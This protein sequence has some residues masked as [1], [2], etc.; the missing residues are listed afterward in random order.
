MLKENNLFNRNP[1]RLHIL[2]AKS[3]FV[4]AGNTGCRLQMQ[5]EFVCVLHVIPVKCLAA[6]A[7]PDWPVK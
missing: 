1:P 2:K 6:H 7:D 4:W 3:A 5:N